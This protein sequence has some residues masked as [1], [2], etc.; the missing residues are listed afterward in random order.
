MV[1]QESL[2]TKGE[3]ILPLSNQILGDVQI[4]SRIE[5]AQS[6]NEIIITQKKYALG[7]LNEPGMLDCRPIDSPIDPNQKLLP[8]KGES[9]SYLER[10][11]GLVGYSSTSLLQSL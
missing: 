1:Y 7:I 11:R 8:I 4:Y 3:P 6:K 2:L 5:V 10:Y 9:Y